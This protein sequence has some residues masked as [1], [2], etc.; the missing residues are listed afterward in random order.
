ISSLPWHFNVCR[1]RIRATGD[2]YS[3]FSPTGNA[4]FHEVL[5]FGQLYDGRSHEFSHAAPDADYL[6]ARRTASALMTSGSQAEA[7]TA[8]TA[9]ADGEVTDF[10]KSDA[11]EQAAICAR[12]LK[13]FDR[14]MELADQIPL[15]A[16]AKTVRMHNLLAMRKPDQ[17][18]ER[19]EDEDIGAWPFWTAGAAWFVRGRA[20]AETGDGPRAE[21]DLQK[22]LEFTTENRARL[23]IWLVLGGNRET[24]LKDDAAALQA[25]QQIAL[26]NRN[27]GSATYFRGV[28]GAARILSRQGKHDDALDTLR[29]VDVSGLRGYWYGAILLA[30]GETLKAAGRSDEALAAYRKLVADDSVIPQ[31]RDAAQQAI[32]TM[33]DKDSR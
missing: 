17:L 25:F 11:L 33:R 1:Q 5:K 2:E 16:V 29:I 23:D 14:A 30:T 32:Q 13:D 20:F 8:F 4:H 24:N 15:E 22:A 18:I 7:L 27:N 28:Q 21:S 10:Q 19:F 31:H 12:A 3:A 26:E 6:Q 9:M